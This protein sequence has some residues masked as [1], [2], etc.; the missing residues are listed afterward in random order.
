MRVTAQWFALNVPMVAL[1]A[2]LYWTGPVAYLIWQDRTMATA[3]IV[4]LG[5][6]TIAATLPRAVQLDRY[7]R[8]VHHEGGRG[9]GTHISGLDV[10]HPGYHGDVLVLERA[11][12]GPHGVLLTIGLVLVGLG[13]LFTL[14]GIAQGFAE[15]GGGVEGGLAAM[16]SDPAKHAKA[17]SE[18]LSW[19]AVAVHTSIAGL[20]MNLW[21]VAVYLVL[22]KA[23]DQVLTEVLRDRVE[24]GGDVP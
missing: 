7:L 23:A 19:L 10:L 14:V 17:T 21:I 22:E 12:S 5:L 6:L 13:F 4:V 20:G 11:L 18:L 2:I 3:G 8:I 24:H 16:F 9:A 15:F 1:A